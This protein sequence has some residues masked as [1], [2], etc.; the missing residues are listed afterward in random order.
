MTRTVSIGIYDQV[1]ASNYASANA[2]ALL[3]LV[4]CFGVLTLVYGLHRRDA[5]KNLWRM[6]P[7]R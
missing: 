2:M 5:V 1:Q 6:G 3:L 4:L 7:V